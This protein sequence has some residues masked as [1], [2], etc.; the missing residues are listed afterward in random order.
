[1]KYVKKLASE[2]TQVEDIVSP[3]IWVASIPGF[4]FSTL[5]K[6]CNSSKLLSIAPLAGQASFK[7]SQ[8]SHLTLLSPNSPKP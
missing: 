1:V 4:S 7:D 2:I 6:G 5:G 8:H 3:A